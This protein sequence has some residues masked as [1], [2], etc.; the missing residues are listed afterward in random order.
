[1]S[2]LFAAAIVLLLGDVAAATPIRVPVDQTQSSVTVTLCIAGRCDADTSP[3]TGELWIQLAPLETPASLTLYDFT[4]ALTETLQFNISWGFLGNFAATGSNIT[5]LY[6]TPFVPHPPAAVTGGA[7][8]CANVPALTTGTMSYTAT[9]VPCA[10]LQG[11]GKPCTDSVNLADQ[12]V[13][14]GDLA[15]TVS[16]SP[17]RVVTVVMQ[18]NF[19]GPLDPQNPSLGTITVT[20]TVRGAVAVPLRGDVNLDGVVDGR[21][22]AAFAAVLLQPDGFAWP[23]RF[24]AD[25]NDDQLFDAADTALFI[26]ALLGVE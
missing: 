21:D 26:A 6:A 12:G 18:P 11:A 17:A 24:A 4:F 15:G 5:L 16:V 10:A 14:T 2:R 13:Q 25:L 23:E 3:V 1:M 8:T 7:F 9:G 22:V 20:G 19:S